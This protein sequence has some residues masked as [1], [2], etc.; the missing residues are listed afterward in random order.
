MRRDYY[1]T[2]LLVQI[3]N[4]F[5]AILTNGSISDGWWNS[6]TLKKKVLLNDDDAMVIA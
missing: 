6:L 4:T 5:V 1:S 3:Y 2:C